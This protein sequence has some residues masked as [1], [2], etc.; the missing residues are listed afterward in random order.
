VS[1][2]HRPWIFGPTP[3]R[4]RTATLL[5]GPAIVVYA[6]EWFTVSELLCCSYAVA[7]TAEAPNVALFVSSTL[8]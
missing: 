4:C 7:V 8:G 1:A 5:G 2:P 6:R 3:G